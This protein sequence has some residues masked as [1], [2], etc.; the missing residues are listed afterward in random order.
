MD[1]TGTPRPRPRWHHASTE[2]DDF[3]IISYRVEPDL[4]SQHLP[5]G[6]VP[7]VLRFDDGGQ[8]TLVSAVVF[9]DRDL[10]FRFCPPVS[11]SCGQINYRAYVS[12]GENR[13]VWFFGIAFDHPL[14]MVPRLLWQM[15]W[16]RA[17]I[18]VGAADDRW[19][20]TAADPSGTSH[21]ELAVTGQ[22]LGRLDGFSDVSETLGRLTHP[23]D[24]WYQRRDTGIGHYSIWHD[25]L[26][27]RQC[28]LTSA[29]FTFLESLGLITP[30]SEPHSA[31]TQPTI[32]FDIHTPPRRLHPQ[33]LPAPPVPARPK[34]GAHHDRS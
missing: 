1:F 10:H 11:I 18:R 3:A 5:P 30:V 17:R 2:L 25:V 9:R 34:G 12:A 21:C 27:A 28:T 20:M 6:V 23:T 19:R 7:E 24:G 13:G 22:P 14:F 33:P 32:H 31:F 4:V 29:R 26:A 16:H 8:G 15:P